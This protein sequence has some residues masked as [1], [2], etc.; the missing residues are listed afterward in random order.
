MIDGEPRWRPKIEHYKC[1]GYGACS[2]NDDTA[3]QL[4][5]NS[6]ADVTTCSTRQ[7]GDYC[8]DYH[9]DLGIYRSLVHNPDRKK[10]LCKYGRWQ[11][12]DK[13]YCVFCPR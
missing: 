1:L 5:S 12:V 3:S 11:E 10:I 9:C 13:Q 6:Y 7:D 4:R 8:E 2:I